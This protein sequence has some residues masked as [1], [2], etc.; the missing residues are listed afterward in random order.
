MQERTYKRFYGLLAQR[1]AYV[2]KAYMVRGPELWQMHDLHTAVQGG[3][4]AADCI[5]QRLAAYHAASEGR[6]PY[7]FC[8][9]SIGSDLTETRVQGVIRITYAIIFRQASS[10]KHAL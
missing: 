9:Y 1:F 10:I 8:M 5:A 2:N 3:S 7:H 6:L 4:L